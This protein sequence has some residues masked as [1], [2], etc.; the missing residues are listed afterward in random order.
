MHPNQDPK[1]QQSATPATVLPSTFADVETARSIVAEC[2]GIVA[3][4]AEQDAT[5]TP[6][7][8]SEPFVEFHGRTAAEARARRAL[9]ALD[10]VNAEAIAAPCSCTVEED[11]EAFLG[12]DTADRETYGPLDV[13]RVCAG[14][15]YAAEKDGVAE[16]EAFLFREK[17]GARS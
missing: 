3:R 8:A 10:E 13:D 16:A 12:L 5:P 14:C 11:P 9:N 2:R 1:N 15:I 4:M 7:A 17:A 6:R